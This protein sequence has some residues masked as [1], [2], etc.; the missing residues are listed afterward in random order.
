MELPEIPQVLI[1]LAYY[2]II[3]E[4]G[5]EYYLEFVWIIKLVGK[6]SGWQEVYSI[7]WIL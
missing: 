3:M 7:Y 2:R 6:Q 5:G 1:S 4:V